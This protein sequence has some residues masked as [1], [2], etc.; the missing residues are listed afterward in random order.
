MK[1]GRALGRWPK[2]FYKVFKSTRFSFPD[3]KNVFS[4]QTENKG[5]AYPKLLKREI[6]RR[7]ILRQKLGVR[8]KSFI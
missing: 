3:M 7:V 2:E 1:N 5:N 8:E 4:S 6:E